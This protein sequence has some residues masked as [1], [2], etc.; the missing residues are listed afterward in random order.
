VQAVAHRQIVLFNP[1]YTTIGNQVALPMALI[2][3]GGALE[4]AGYRVRLIDANI[5]PEWEPKLQAALP[6]ALALGITT[7]TGPMAAHCAI[8]AK[9][10]R[11]WRPDLPI[12]LGGWHPSL[13][14]AGT[15]KQPWC[16]VVVK[17][18]GEITV[19]ELMRAL[20]S[21]RD[22]SEVPGLY[23]KCGGSVV[24]S[25][26]RPFADINTLP[27][28]AYHLIDLQP[29][30][31]KNRGVHWVQ[32]FTSYG[33]PYECTYC[34]N[35]AIFNRRW[36][37]LKVERIVAELRELVEV[38]DA[39]YIGFVDDNFFVSERHMVALCSAIVASG[40]QFK[41]SAQGRAD[42]IA[43]YSERAME[44]VRASGCDHIFF[45]AETGSENVLVLMKKQET[46]AD[47]VR[48]AARC[49]QHGIT[50]GFY[51]IFGYPGETEVDIQATLRL[52]DQIKGT[53][54]AAELY[55][56][57][58]TPYPGCPAYDEA[59]RLGVREPETFEEWGRFTPHGMEL[60][61]L[62]GEKLRRI[63]RMRATLREAYPIHFL[64]LQHQPAPGR[65][66]RIRQKIAQARLAHGVYAL[67]I[68]LWLAQISHRSS[69][70]AT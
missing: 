33:C 26:E 51:F 19:V 5:D 16:D 24:H 61:W 29:Y 11:S 56:N 37:V 20:E 7:L 48:S 32:Y 28:K 66:G 54:P 15:A 10:V 38:Y 47:V 46:N 3:I 60:P 63:N 43:R 8:V 13:L 49:H 22:L 52:I 18:Q 69:T 14:P 9:K 35:P 59:L 1:I 64:G 39:R 45:G 53:N 2:T 44:L 67:P 41:W 50:S 4:A 25:S 36:N 17:G 12:V 6:G 30:Y 57:I 55:T 23:F 65:W 70:V 34:S 58:F 40:L 42:R 31:A 21:G 62:K 68:D 27:K